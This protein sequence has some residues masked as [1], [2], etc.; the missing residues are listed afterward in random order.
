MNHSCNR[1]HRLGWIFLGP[2]L[3][4]GC[5][6]PQFTT[7]TIY[8]TPPSFVRLNVDRTLDPGTG[9]SHPSAIT[10]EQM[11]AVLRGITIQEP[12]TRLPLIDD[13]SVPRRHPAFSDRA[14]DFWAPLL[15]LALSKAT[16][17]EIITFYQSTKGSGTSREVTSGGM[18]V[19]GDTLH[20]ILS[21][22]QSNTHFAA[23]IGVADSQD[24]R[25]APMR[26]IAPQRGKLMFFPESARVDE[27]EDLLDGLTRVFS[28]DRRE[29]VVLY[30][31]LSA[32]QGG[33]NPH[34]TE[35]ST[36]DAKRPLH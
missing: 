4:I 14:V 3:L 33:L 28:Q 30:K 7:L 5:A 31:T 18:F 29:L 34:S 6:A 19:D 24:D 12:L 11:A 13:L 35:N 1:V 2:L 25:L 26:S 32:E 17:A 27:G 20:I 22:L 36:E 9:H 15:S 23:D 16:A 10:S 8:E 21:N